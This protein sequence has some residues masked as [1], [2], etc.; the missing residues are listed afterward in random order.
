MFTND[1]VYM[2]STQSTSVASVAWANPQTFDKI[3]EVIPDLHGLPERAFDRIPRSLRRRVYGVPY[4][5]LD[6][7]SGGQLWVTSHGWRL[8]EHLDPAKWYF[9]D[10]YATRGKMLS[11]GSGTV[12]R[13]PSPIPAA[14]PVDLVVKFS[15]MAQDVPL[16]ASAQTVGGLPRHVLDGFGY[17]DPFQEFGLLEELRNSRFGPSSPRIRT[18]RPLAIYSPAKPS[19]PWQLG[20]TE[21]RFQRHRRELAKDQS[22]LENRSTAV[23]ISIDRQYVYLFHWVRGVDAQTL[24]RAGALSGQEASALVEHVTED[25]AAK[26]FRVL[27]TKP[28]HVILRQRPDGQLLRRGGRL[29]YALVDFELLQR[30]EE[31]S[32]WLGA[33]GKPLDTDPSK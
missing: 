3:G 5:Q 24:L 6:D 1:D 12:Y 26:G 17:N 4:V 14:R 27:D 9:D 15:R 23:E 16:D 31:Y 25:L 33:A 11:E 7:R 30:T 22:T 13:V 21:D 32:R 8:L 10:Q 18:K 20:R 28:G 29:V 2:M 19:E